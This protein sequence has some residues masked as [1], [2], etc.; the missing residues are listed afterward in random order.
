MN[1]IWV[2]HSKESVFLHN[3][4]LKRERIN[5]LN[6]NKCSNPGGCCI[7]GGIKYE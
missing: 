5:S 6:N 4:I 3:F 1:A 2:R 7:K